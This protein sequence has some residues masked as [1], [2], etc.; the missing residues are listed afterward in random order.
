MDLLTK[1]Q[2]YGVVRCF[3]YSVEWQKRGLPHTHILIWME[4]SIPPD[5]VDKVIFAEIPD[6]EINPQLFNIVR[7][8]KL[9][10]PCCAFSVR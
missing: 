8:H 10:G 5:R 2:I 4:E 6:T 9:H 1:G 7:T 3:M